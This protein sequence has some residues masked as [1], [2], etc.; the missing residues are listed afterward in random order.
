MLSLACIVR[1]LAISVKTQR[2]K[3]PDILPG[4]AIDS[5]NFLLWRLVER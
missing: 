4:S 1:V 2:T 5:D 3:N